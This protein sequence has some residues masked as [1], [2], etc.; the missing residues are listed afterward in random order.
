MSRKGR[1]EIT[2]QEKFKD[3]IESIG[4][5][6]VMGIIRNTENPINKIEIDKM[7]NWNDLYNECNLFK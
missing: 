3:K 5:D 2:F 7:K 4:K 1:T 6:G